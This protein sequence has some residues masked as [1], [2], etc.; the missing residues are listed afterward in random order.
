MGMSLCRVH[1][2]EGRVSEAGVNGVNHRAL[3]SIVLDRLQALKRSGRIRE[4]ERIAKDHLELA[5]EALG[6]EQD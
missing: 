6:L 5:L 3:V 2:Q 1:F 4:G